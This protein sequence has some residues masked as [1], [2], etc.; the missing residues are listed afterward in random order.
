MGAVGLI[1]GV[2]FTPAKPGDVLTVYGIS[3]GPTNPATM[4][5]VPPSSTAT[6]DHPVLTLGGVGL[7]TSKLP[8]VGVSPG[9]AGLYQIN[10]QVPGG[11]P[12][13]DYPLT[14]KLG[15]FSTPP[16]GFITIKN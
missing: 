8:Y 15:T 11:L 5:G 9:I 3:F 10:F 6:V 1:P 7:D 14:M 13:G 16:G 2:S 4:P 12:D